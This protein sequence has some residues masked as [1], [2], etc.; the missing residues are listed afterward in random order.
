MIQNISIRNYREEGNRS[1]PWDKILVFVTCDGRGCL[2]DLTVQQDQLGEALQPVEQ[3]AA[4]RRADHRH[5]RANLIP[6]F[7]I[8]NFNN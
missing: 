2:P 1:E 8:N 4:V 3:A 7:Q 6:I 5:I